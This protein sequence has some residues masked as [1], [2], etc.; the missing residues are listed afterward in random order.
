M[1][2]LNFFLPSGDVDFTVNLVSAT[3]DAETTRQ[4]FDANIID[5]VFPES[6][7]SFGV[8]FRIPGVPPIQSTVTIIDDDGTY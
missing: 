3:F 6:D 5:D 7:E 1:T 2:N 8:D 4:C